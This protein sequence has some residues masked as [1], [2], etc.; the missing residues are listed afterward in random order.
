MPQRERRR[1]MTAPFPLYVNEMPGTIPARVM[2]WFNVF[3][4]G[5]G[6]K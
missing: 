6:I 2:S 5:H 4:D 1:L 3:A